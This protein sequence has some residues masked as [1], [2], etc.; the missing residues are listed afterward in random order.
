VILIVVVVVVVVETV[1]VVVVDSGDHRHSLVSMLTMRSMSCF[2]EPKS[3]SSIIWSSRRTS[4]AGG[5]LECGTAS[6]REVPGLM[7]SG[8]LAYALGDE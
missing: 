7:G 3:S 4:L 2:P 8:G 5:T 6:V 1:V